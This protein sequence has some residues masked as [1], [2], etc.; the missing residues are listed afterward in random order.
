MVP[1]IVVAQAGTV[2]RFNCT[3]TN[4][5]PVYWRTIPCGSVAENEISIGEDAM[6]GDYGRSERF[7]VEIDSTLRRHDLVIKDIKQSDGGVY[8]CIAGRGFGNKAS[9]ELVVWGKFCY[10]L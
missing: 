7:S 4:Q 5:E 8:I 3:S 6:V 2:A 1:T 9:A 10:Y